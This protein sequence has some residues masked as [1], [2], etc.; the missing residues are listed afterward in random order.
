M[1][2]H[3][4]DAFS[5]EI[6]E[7]TSLELLNEREK[8]WIK[9]F[10]TR[11]CGYNIRDGGD[12][13]NTW[14]GLTPDQR[15]ERIRKQ[16]EAQKSTYTQERK[17]IMAKIL[18]DI[19]KDPDKS[20]L[21]REMHSAR[22][23][24]LNADPE[25][26]QKILNTQNEKALIRIKNGDALIKSKTAYLTYNNVSKTWHTQFKVLAIG[27]MPRRT[28]RDLEEAL[29]FRNEWLEAHGIKVPQLDNSANQHLG[30]EPTPSGQLCA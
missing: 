3:G 26:R 16:S 8:Y 20:K 2:K 4:L 5:V 1:R 27:I 22:F 18:K 13:G 30:L 24:I 9:I 29:A 19:R 6:L 11:E 7:N 14:E 15:A 17:D 21:N 23:K 28:F 25:W 12:G 10:K